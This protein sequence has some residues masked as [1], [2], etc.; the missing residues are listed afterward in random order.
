MF[1]RLVLLAA[2][3]WLAGCAGTIQRDSAGGVR[4]IEGA[5]YSGVD[6]VLGEQ[7]RREQG[8][9][10]QFNVRD[11][12]D[13]I[14][15]RLESREL[16]ATDGVLRVEVSIDHVRVR[17][18][19]AAVILGA[20]AGADTIDGYVRIY[21]ARGR[22]VHGYK[23]N[24]TYALGGAAGGQDGMRMTWLYDKFAEL[25]VTELAGETPD[26]SLARR[27]AAPAGPAVAIRPQPAPTGPAVAIAPASGFAALDDVDA[28]PYLNERGRQGYRDWL[29]RSTPRAFAISSKGNWY[30]T[31][32]LA[33]AD[34]TLPKDPAER[35]LLMCERAAHVPCRLYAVNGA[36]VW[37]RD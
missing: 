18:V 33:P 23:V 20:M 34:A 19:A 3:L 32:G 28:V 17:S 21:D 5:R 35:A 22:Q 6:V 30:A 8:D 29:R 9:N 37:N 13:Y 1:H 10:P 7:A 16:L 31:N 27:R 24:A 36:V 11:L 2:V 4:R 12:G 25:A 15:R 14:R 26:T